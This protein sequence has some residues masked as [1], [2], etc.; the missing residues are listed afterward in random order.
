VIAG[1]G[2]GKDKDY[3]D[4][5]EFLWHLT[6]SKP[7]L[8]PDGLG[9]DSRTLPNNAKERLL[10]ILKQLPSPTIWCSHFHYLTQRYQRTPSP[11]GVCFTECIPHALIKHAERYSL[12]GLLFR[13]DRAY[14]KGARPV[15]YIE[16]EYL[17]RFVDVKCDWQRG[18]KE[19]LPFPDEL[20]HLLM[21]FVPD[22][23]E[24]SMRL[25]SDHKLDWMV[26]REWRVAGD[27]VFGFDDIAAII[28]PTSRDMDWLRQEIQ[29]L[30]DIDFVVTNDLLDKPFEHKD[31]D[32]FFWRNLH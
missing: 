5:S 3:P 9:N 27:F 2:V 32:K 15:W 18:N 29:D 8:S 26:E 25:L 11:K 10:S 13:K 1:Y 14:S 19:K 22:Y 7:P 16:I 23:D 17:N 6:K 21:P 20:L 12:W 24:H 4:H 30:E 28:V 31:F